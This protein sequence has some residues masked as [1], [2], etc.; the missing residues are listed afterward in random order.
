MKFVL[1]PRPYKC[2][3]IGLVYSNTCVR[4]FSSEHIRDRA[5]SQ[6]QFMNG[7]FLKCVYSYKINNNKASS[8]LRIFILC[9]TVNSTS[10]HRH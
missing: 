2:L 5:L 10:F 1:C 6:I 3:N 7:K 4:H 9:S 8:Y